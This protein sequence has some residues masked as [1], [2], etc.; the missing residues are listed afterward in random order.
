MAIKLK[1]F[2]QIT[3]MITG[4]ALSGLVFTGIW[5]LGK[6][7][8]TRESES[9]SARLEQT[10]KELKSLEKAADDRLSA[11]AER[12]PKDNATANLNIGAS[13]ETLEQWGYSG[14]FAPWYWSQLN[15]R[16]K[17]CGSKT[18]QSPV[19][20]SGA[21][22]DENLKALKLN[23]SHGVTKLTFHHQTIQ[24]DIE[25]GSWLDWNGERF[26]LTKVYFRTPSEHRV[27]SLPWEMEVQLEHTAVT[28]S[29]IMLSV[30]MTPGKSHDLMARIAANLPRVKDDVRDIERVQWLDLMPRKKTYWT[31]IGSSTLPPC[32]SNVR[33]IIIHEP[34][35]TSK[36]IIDRF[37]LMQKTNVRPIYRIGNRV[38]TRSNR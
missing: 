12:L 9:E 29:K 37:V 34:Q 17:A 18:N 15:D 13:V 27:N 32:E 1:G 33:W 38:I 28:G 22:E 10:E 24:G 30:L 6:C 36:T 21:R 19:D 35:T 5:Y 20:I 23:Y 4:T 26:D 7:S 8:A 31:Y 16:W 11:T 25:R 14:N 2:D 3:A